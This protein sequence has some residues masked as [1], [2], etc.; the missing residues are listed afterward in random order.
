M[1]EAIITEYFPIHI[2]PSA[3]FSQIIQSFTILPN[4]VS[5]TN[6]G[7]RNLSILNMLHVSNS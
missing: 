1:A 4:L 5:P 7:P 6:V 2:Q 3:L